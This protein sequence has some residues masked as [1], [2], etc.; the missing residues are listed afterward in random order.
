MS[1]TAES[2]CE[3]IIE[4]Q[5]RKNSSDVNGTGRAQRK[6]ILLFIV[7]SRHLIIQTEPG[8][9]KIYH[10]CPHLVVGVAYKYS[11]VPGLLVDHTLYS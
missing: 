9:G 11:K 5:N 8:I 6:H 4:N 3:Y 2:G 10:S 1:N 7:H